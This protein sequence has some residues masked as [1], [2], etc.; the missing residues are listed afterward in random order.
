MRDWSKWGEII[1]RNFLAL[2]LDPQ[3][4]HGAPSQRLI[5]TKKPLR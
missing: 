5:E 2:T 4:L 3:L 1:E